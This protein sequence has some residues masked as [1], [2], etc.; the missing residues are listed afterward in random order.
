MRRRS[1]D[2]STYADLLKR[3]RAG[4]TKPVGTGSRFHPPAPEVFEEG[5]TTVVRN[6]GEILGVIRRTADHAVPTFLKALGRAGE[7]EGGRLVLQGKA[8]TAQVKG[9]LDEYIATF[10]MCSE[11]GA[12]DTHL[13]RDH[14]VLVVQCDACGAHRPVKSRAKVKEAKEEGPHV[15]ME[16]EVTIDSTG[17]QGDGVARIGNY[18]VFVKGAVKGQTVKARVNGVNGNLVF[19]EVLPAPQ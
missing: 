17:R 8:T 12:P 18:T 4:L 9:R 15:G 1:M 14:R 10:V 13:V 3:G 7:F 6:F 11:C 19:A 16:L 2:P 5:R